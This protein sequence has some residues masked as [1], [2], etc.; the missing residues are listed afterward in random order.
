MSKVKLEELIDIDE[1]SNEKFSVETSI[2]KAKKILEF[3]RE[4]DPI[5]DATFEDDKW[6]F[7]R[8]LQKGHTVNFNFFELES[9]AK[10]H[11]WNSSTV[12]LVKC[13]VAELL[14]Q[15]YPGGVFSS[16]S[17]LLQMIEI[18]DFFNPKKVK[19]TYDYLREY[20]PAVKKY[21][22]E[23]EIMTLRD[24]KQELKEE[25][26][27]L[28]V[29]QNMITAALNFL[30][31]SELD[32]FHSYNSPLME[33]KKAL[34]RKPFA[35][36]LPSG[37]DVL[38][39]DNCIDRY[40]AQGIDSSSRLFFTPIL[41]WWKLTN[42]IP[43]RISEFCTI[44]RACLS[45][46]NGTYYISLPREKQRAS[47]RRVQVTDT[48][49]IT[50]DIFALFN[51]YIQLTNQY[52][53]SKTLVSYKT[54]MALDE[55]NTNRIRKRNYEY[56]NSGS[57]DLLLKRFYKEILYGEY[58]Y[59]VEQ[60]VRP[61]DTRH[62]AFC[63]LLM[64]GI[65]PIEIARLG[66]HSTIEAQYHYSNHTEYFIDV[67]VKKLIDGFTKKDGKLRGIFEGQEITYEDIEQKSYQFPYKNTRLE[68]EIGYCTDKL[69]RCESDECMLCNHWWIHPKDLLEVKP[70][71]EEKIRKRKQK[72][73]EMGRFLKNLNESFTETMVSDL[74]P[75]VFTSMNTKGTAIQDHLVEIARLEILKGED[76][77]E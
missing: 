76:I 56:L 28:G 37:K 44:K 58:N 1:L 73:I 50:K 34:P 60:E 14:S 41:L 42:V 7:E 62:F 54:I 10:F 29:V 30:T 68:V 53:E 43:M 17:N 13:W 47:K 12:D 46:E 63:S 20:S 11:K 3:L 67:E 52:G 39:L 6:S 57:F 77:D 16:F 38:K 66:G 49:E 27:G 19:V 21:L 74:D 69:Q 22:E 75:A 32:S 23:K 4:Q 48:L 72:I 31:Y 9:S 26:S 35:R 65:S 25:R 33:I 71:I 2:K 51:E 55:K 70:L 36:Q 59:E 18:T 40:F 24:I 5:F 45:E 61:N 8:H 15:Y 64:Q